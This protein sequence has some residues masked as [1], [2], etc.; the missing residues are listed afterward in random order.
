MN[1][2]SPEMTVCYI[3]VQNY[4]F[5]QLKTVNLGSCHILTKDMHTKPDHLIFFSVIQKAFD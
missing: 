5:H 2:S 3:C 4:T 1:I